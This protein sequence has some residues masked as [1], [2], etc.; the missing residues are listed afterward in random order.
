MRI[1]RVG[2]AERYCDATV[3]N[4]VAYLAGAVGTP[5]SGISE[6]TAQALAEVDR[7]LALV[8]S[9][10]SNILMAT[11]WLAN[12]AD[13]EAMNAAWDTWVDRDNPPARATSEARLARDHYL[14]EVVVTAALNPP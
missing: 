5:G 7:I 10:K 6:Q 4:G 2:K 13:Y 3:Y 11:I 8:G 14:V 12:I 1:T 9:S